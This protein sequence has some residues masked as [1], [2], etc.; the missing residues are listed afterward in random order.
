V[1]IVA[2]MPCRNE[3]WILGPSLRAL[4]AWADDVIVLN[5][6]STDESARILEEVRDEFRDRVFV[7]YEPD[8]TWYEM[9]HRQRLLG[10][11]RSRG[12]SHVAIVDADEV[13]SGNLVNRIRLM[14]DTA[15]ADTV[16]QLPWVCLARELGRRYISGIW[17]DNWVS[18]A[19]RDSAA[20]HWHSR[21]GYDF[22]HRHPMGV[23]W[24]AY[25]P[26]AQ[27]EGGLMHLQFVDER[28]LRAKQALYQLTERLRWPGRETV[29]AVRERYSPAVYQSNPRMVGTADIP[30]SWWEPYAS[31]KQH[32]HLGGE[33]WQEV[34]CRR[35]LDEHPGIESGLDLFGLE[36]AC[37][38]R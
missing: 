10:V 30:E 5:H 7:L 23:N 35:I 28:R 12:A 18:T 34:E 37:S 14:I 9:A 2:I 29:D 25:R 3:G 8:P 21:A 6:A 33:P 11:A 1:K 4:L 22:H 19:F 31:L 20:A 36:A 15:P 26:I 24:Q 32:L 16:L 27:H 17:F 13:L 38:R